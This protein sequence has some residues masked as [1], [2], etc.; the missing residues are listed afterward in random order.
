ME[1]EID[2]NE[3]D[4]RDVVTRVMEECKASPTAFDN[5]FPSVVELGIRTPKT[6]ILPISAALQMS[7]IGEAPRTPQTEAE[8]AR[9]QADI[10]ALGV[11][12]GFPLFVKSSFTSSKHYWAETCCLP[13][14]S[15]ETVRKHI[16][17]IFFYQCMGPH[18]LTPSIV[19]REMI[20]TKPAF[21]AFPGKMPVTQEFRFFAGGGTAFGYHPY[22]PVDSIQ[23]PDREDWEHALASMSRPSDQQLAEM[24]AA[25]ET[26]SK[27][28][29]G[30]WSV[31]F[32]IDQDGKPWLIDMAEAALS[33]ISQKEFVP[34]SEV[35]EPKVKRRPS[36]EDDALS[37]GL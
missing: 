27:K 6:S 30:A 33:Y 5:W 36:P 20:K 12:H 19:V 15:I 26:L 11:Q 3:Q 29:G 16:G 1:F 18:P 37:M 25:A 10:Q 8:L 17:E 24:K 28:L 35:V 23:D 21:H 22:W 31:D 4:G 32:L 9:M 7:L 34:L 13:D 14:A 2:L